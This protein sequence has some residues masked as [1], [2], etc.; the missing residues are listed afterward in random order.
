MRI[1]K[2][3]ILESL[4]AFYYSTGIGAI[5]FDKE[6]HVVASSP[7]N[8]IIYNFQILGMNQINALLTSKFL[9][10]LDDNHIFYTFFLESNL[11]CNVSFIIKDHTYSGVYV[12]QPVFIK[13]PNQEE[14][15]QILSKYN[16]SVKERHALQNAFLKVPVIKYE[17]VMPM[18]RVLHSLSQ[19]ISMM[20]DVQQVLCGSDYKQKSDVDDNQI[21]NVDFISNKK[22]IREKEFAIFLKMKELIQDGNPEGMDTLLSSIS[23]GDV[24]AEKLINNDFKRSL[25]LTF[26]KTCTM[27]CFFA[28]DAGLHYEKAFDLSDDSIRQ[29]E[30][31]ENINDLYQLM[32][33]TMIAF[34]R[35]VS[36]SRT[37]KY[38]KPVNQSLDYISKHYNSNISLSDLSKTTKLSTFYLSSIIKKETGMSLSENINQIRIEKSKKILLSTNSNIL[39]VAQQVGY[40]YQNH[41]ASIFKKY[42]GFSPT[43]F[44]IVIGSANNINNKN[45]SGSS[46]VPFAISYLRNKLKILNGNYDYARVVDTKSKKSWLVN[47]K[48]D[49]IPMP[50]LCYEF[51]NRNECCD[52]C[53]SIMSCIKNEPMVKVVDQ[54]AEIFLVI[55][56]PK[57]MEEN[58]YGIEIIKNV[59]DHFVF[60]TDN[61][62]GDYN[63]D[64]EGKKEQNNHKFINKKLTTC[65]NRS[66]IKNEPLT[67][68]LAQVII[69][70]DDYNA[71]HKKLI[72]QE[73]EKSICRSF[74]SEEDWH[75]SYIG[76]IFIIILNKTDHLKAQQIVKRI[77]K[78]FENCLTKLDVENTPTIVQYGIKSVSNQISDADLLLKL[79]FMDLYDHA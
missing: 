6:L 38:S 2:T 62:N 74:R 46:E 70:C 10:S 43:E 56:L 15:D 36:V 29:M 33:S 61:E 53:I 31:T 79:A 72:M 24:Q 66:K 4:N 51:W 57:I 50:K 69:N 28:I 40:N 49:T 9:E 3:R 68:V 47:P 71:N 35:A 14:I 34:A 41:F 52:D 77:Q 17:R 45:I 60:V 16:L 19:S 7:S 8:H 63:S 58:K 55:A 44:R 18:G 76:D 78:N 22:R 12:S 21:V 48:D 20:P 11:I 39:D 64:H 5:C 67:L 23:A 32:K 54:G 75:E 59:T 42:T 27:V 65:I 26:I 1:E 73:Y 37:K 13:A 30:K 25:E